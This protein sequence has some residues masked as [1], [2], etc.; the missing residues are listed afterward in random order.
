M[1]KPS[2][3]QIKVLL[4]NEKIRAIISNDTDINLQHLQKIENLNSSD[5]EK[6]QSNAQYWVH[7]YGEQVATYASQYDYEINPIQIKSVDS[8][9]LVEIIDD[10][11]E[12]FDSKDQAI[13]YADENIGRFFVD[14]E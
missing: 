1:A 5:F 11:P 13:Q 6:I 14:E 9:Y 3:E 2:L 8:L 10:E 4:G 7:H 12:F